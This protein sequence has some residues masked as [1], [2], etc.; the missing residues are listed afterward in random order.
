MFRGSNLRIKFDPKNGMEVIARG[1]LIRLRRPRRSPAHRRG[2]AA[3]GNRRGRTRAAATE[4]EAARAR[5]TSTPERKRRLPRFP[6][7]VGLIAKRQWRGHPR[8]DRTLRPALAPDGTGHPPE[9]G[10]GRWRRRG[11]RRRDPDAQ[12]LPRHRRVAARRHR[13][14]P[15]R[16]QH[17]G[18]VGVQRGG[19]CGQRSSNS[20]VPVVSAVGHEIDVTVADLVADHRAETPSAA[21]VALTPD[22]RELMASLL[23]LR[24]PGFARRSNTGS[25]WPAPCRTTRLRPALRRPL[26]RIRDLEQRLDDTA[27]RL[28]SGREPADDSGRGETC[29]PCGAA[30]NALPLERSDSRI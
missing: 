7:R 12:P 23:D 2:I 19:R 27:G 25:N 18:P 30:G 21:V 28:A 4:G 26:Q 8:H 3:E 5:G 22:R 20:V 6:Q 17:R 24:E 16:R 14:R 11:D 15:R 1:R 10:A 13:A 9:S 29:G